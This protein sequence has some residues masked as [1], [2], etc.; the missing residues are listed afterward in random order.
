MQWRVWYGDGSTADASTHQPW[1]LDPYDAQ[2]VGQHNPDHGFTLEFY[3]DYALWRSDLNAW[4]PVRGHDGLIDQ[5]AAHAR[6]IDAVLMGRY[7]R[8]DQWEALLSK[9]L[10]EA[11]KHTWTA[12]EGHVVERRTGR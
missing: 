7:M 5:L 8:H 4:I 1:E 9:V 2:I 3:H 12:W 6:D 11:G 10:E